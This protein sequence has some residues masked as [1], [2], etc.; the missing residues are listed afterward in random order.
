MYTGPIE[1]W[2]AAIISAKIETTRRHRSCSKH[3]VEQ[4]PHSL[5]TFFT[6]IMM[7]ESALLFLAAVCLASAI[8]LSS[9]ATASCDD[10]QVGY[11]KMAV[12]FTQASS[13]TDA[14]A[15]NPEYYQFQLCWANVCAYTPATACTY[16]VSSRVPGLPSCVGGA[17][18][19]RFCLFLRSV[20]F[21]FSIYW[22]E[23][24]FSS[25]AQLSCNVR[26]HYWIL[27]EHHTRR[28]EGQPHLFALANLGWQ[29]QPF[30]LDTAVFPKIWAS[31]L[32][33]WSFSRTPS[34]TLVR[35]CVAL[36]FD[37]KDVGGRHVTFDA[38]HRRFARITFKAK[39]H[40]LTDR[41]FCLC[42]STTRL[43]LSTFFS[44]VSDRLTEERSL[45]TPPASRRAP[46]LPRTDSLART[47]PGPPPRRRPSARP[48]QA[49]PA[50][51]GRA[52]AL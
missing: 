45:S 14:A 12:Q 52:V 23:L 6:R 19:I 41:M 20:S 7:K 25:T 36:L 46:C 3:T 49:L 26:C 21:A 4:A 27:D 22:H 42:R 16:S 34:L 38:R 43:P 47:R 15:A 9:A 11:M 33:C 18:V 32:C 29:D 35:L 2:Q 39:S 48:P 13:C 1:S 10:M 30:G 31:F 24:C 44:I 37:F 17:A 50:R 40:L 51:C 8:T 5:C 28:R